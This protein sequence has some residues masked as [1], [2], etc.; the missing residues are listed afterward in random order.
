MSNARLHVHEWTSFF[1]V[2]SA[3][4]AKRDDHAKAAAA[5][6]ARGRDRSRAVVGALG[7]RPGTG[8]AQR[9]QLSAEI[10][11][12]SA[13]QVDGRNPYIAWAADM[14]ADWPPGRQ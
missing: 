14:L 10:G 6:R 4:W 7:R 11:C 1:I 9:Q 8:A 3:G 2:C 13:W 12:G 5:R